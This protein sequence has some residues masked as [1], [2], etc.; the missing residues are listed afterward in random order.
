[1]RRIGKIMIL[2]V[3]VFSNLNSKQSVLRQ[4]ADIMN[5]YANRDVVVNKQKNAFNDVFKN[6]KSVDGL[7]KVIGR[8][9]VNNLL[10][11]YMKNGN[12]S[13]KLCDSNND[14]PIIEEIKDDKGVVSD[15][16]V[17]YEEKSSVLTKY[18]ADTNSQKIGFWGSLWYGVKT[19]TLPLMYTA[20]M[21]YI[22]GLAVSDISCLN[23]ALKLIQEWWDVLSQG[24]LCV[25]YYNNKFNN[26][27]NNRTEN[28]ENKGAIH[29]FF[30]NIIPSKYSWGKY[31]IEMLD[32]VIPFG[33]NYY[34]GKLVRKI[35][36]FKREGYVQAGI[37]FGIF[38]NFFRDVLLRNMGVRDTAIPSA[39]YNLFDRL[40]VT[41]V[42]VC[43]TRALYNGTINSPISVVDANP[44]GETLPNS[45]GFGKGG[46]L[47]R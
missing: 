5:N 25:S 1:M 31:L 26:R 19:Y 11:Y 23:Y 37:T 35:P 34:M 12:N 27:G 20:S 22:G 8:E 42:S 38:Y 46:N 7:E 36:L 24:M 30:E 13:D 45:T 39:W 15:V 28:S 14:G 17:P 32:N 9:G 47:R 29:N 43:Q 40:L 33:A 2:G 44:I 18:N 10:M 3:F 41:A 4:N 21:C 6:V 16:L